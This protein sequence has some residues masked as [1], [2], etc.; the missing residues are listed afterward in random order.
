MSSTTNPAGPHEL[1]QK[2]AVLA[3]RLRKAASATR[4][5]PLSYAQQ[6][7]WFLEQLEPETP[8]YNIGAVA[9]VEGSL[10]IDLLGQAFHAI[11]TRHETLRTR[12]MCPD[13]NP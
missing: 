4:Q 7:L 13:E 10:R 6:R 2:R 9:R 12:F 3:A 5:G 8:L 1:V 11:V